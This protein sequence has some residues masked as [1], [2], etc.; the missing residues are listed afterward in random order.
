MEE[1]TKELKEKIEY[2]PVFIFEGRTVD[3]NPKTPSIEKDGKRYVFL[4]NKL[5]NLV[6]IEV[7]NVKK[8]VSG[9]K[10]Y[11]CYMVDLDNECEIVYEQ[12][13]PYFDEKGNLIFVDID[14]IVPN[15]TSTILTR[16]DNLKIWDFISG[17]THIPRTGGGLMTGRR[18]LIFAFIVGLIVAYFLVK[19]LGI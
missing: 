15:V 4:R 6:K 2:V 14:E 1:E 17:K 5:G 11:I 18:G 10:S 7:N 13:I 16:L 9:S 19:H 8:V 3:F 12:K